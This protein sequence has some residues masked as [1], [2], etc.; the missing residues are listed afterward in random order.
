MLLTE[1]S[2]PDEIVRRV[3]DYLF[4]KIITADELVTLMERLDLNLNR[5]Q[6]ALDGRQGAS[7][8]PLSLCRSY[9]LLSGIKW[10]T[11]SGANARQYNNFTL[12]T[13]GLVILRKHLQGCV[14]DNY[15]K[16]HISTRTMA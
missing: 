16:N 11:S 2:W 9:P 3:A 14:I 5:L 10:L 4:P 8:Q 13:A 1:S 15:P 6:K 12:F 7:Q